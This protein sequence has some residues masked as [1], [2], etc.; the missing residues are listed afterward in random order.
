MTDG[1]FARGF[2]SID[3]AFAVQTITVLSQCRA[4]VAQIVVMVL[5]TIAANLCRA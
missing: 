2:P 4:F 5:T 1:G 3:R